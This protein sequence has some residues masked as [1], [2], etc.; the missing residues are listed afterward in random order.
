M[1]P[2]AGPLRP[3][4]IARLCQLPQQGDHAEL[5]EQ[6]RIEGDLVQA[7]EDVPRRARIALPLD[8]IDLHQDG[9]PRFAFAHERRD[10][11]VSGIAAV[12]IVLAI[13][14]DGL[15]E[16]G[17]ARRGEEHVGRNLAVAEH[18]SPAGVDVGRGDEQLDLASCQPLEIDGLGQDLVKRIG[19]KG[20]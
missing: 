2:H 12:P 11:G 19:S 1:D 9:I 8:G 16:S 18:P 17:Q 4:A 3:F 20:V 7:V 5:F 13:D 14:L 6:H 10:R 15:E